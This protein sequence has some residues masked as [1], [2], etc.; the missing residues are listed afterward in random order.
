[1]E[2]VAA[3]GLKTDERIVLPSCLHTGAK[4]Y[5]DKA[6][7]FSNIN[8]MKA[9]NTLDMSHHHTAVSKDRGKISSSI[10]GEA[11]TLE[12]DKSPDSV[13]AASLLPSATTS[14]VNSVAAVSMTHAV[15]FRCGLSNEFTQ[16]M[17]DD[18]KTH[19]RCLSKPIL[20]DEFRSA[21]PQS[22]KQPSEK[23]QSSG[24]CEQV[25]LAVQLSAA[26]ITVAPLQPPAAEVV[27]LASVELLQS[28]SSSPH[29]QIDTNKTT[30]AHPNDM[31]HTVASSRLLQRP[32]AQSARTSAA[33]ASLDLQQP[34][35]HVNKVLI[36]QLVPAHTSAAPRASFLANIDDTVRQVLVNLPSSML[37]L[38]QV[39]SSEHEG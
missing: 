22:C 34:T 30:A 4:G 29:K 3:D 8:I 39:I 13:F 7:P 23:P 26:T 10:S 37:H 1:M 19:A 6:Q 14:A 21:V 36:E 9:S 31:S 15:Q 12:T 24:D 28:R 32:T 35:L 11:L 20:T 18:G 38:L 5:A 27:A 33:T 25:I 2:L 16:S 17:I